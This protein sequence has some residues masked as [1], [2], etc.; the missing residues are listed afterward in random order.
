MICKLCLHCDWWWWSRRDNYSVRHPC[1]HICCV[2]VLI[3]QQVISKNLEVWHQLNVTIDAWIVLWHDDIILTSFWHNKK[4]TT[5]LISPCVCEKYTIHDFYAWY[6]WWFYVYVKIYIV[7]MVLLI[8][9]F[10]FTFL[11]FVWICVKNP[12]MMIF[13]DTNKKNDRWRWKI[14]PYS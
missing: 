10:D 4:I 8:G 13:V 2:V 9:R 3:G 14:Q 7:L 6:I 11:L 12:S 1:A 5:L